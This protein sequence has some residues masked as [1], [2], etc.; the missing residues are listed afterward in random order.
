MTTLLAKETLNHLQRGAVGGD[1]ACDGGD[2]A[3]RDAEGF[4]GD[5]G[6]ADRGGVEGKYR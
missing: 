3:G 5:D 1:G 2:D 4:K 6:G